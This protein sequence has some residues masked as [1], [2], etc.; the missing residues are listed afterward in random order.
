MSITIHP[1]L[2]TELRA[3]AQAEGIPVEEYL[4]R[5]LRS[6]DETAAELETLA[7]EGV[8]SGDAIV[9]GAEYWDELHRRLENR[10]NTRS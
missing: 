6:E 5:I 9:A 10:V 4:E 1:P 7:M 8:K 3:R 2:E